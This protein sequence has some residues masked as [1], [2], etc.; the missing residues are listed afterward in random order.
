GIF[1]SLAGLWMTG[2]TLNIYSQIGIIMIIGLATKNTILIVEFAN[3]LRDE[4][5]AIHQAVWQASEERLRPILMTTVSTAIGALPLM[6]S[7]GAGAESR[8]TLG[9]VIF[10]GT[11]VAAVFTLIATPIA[12]TYIAPYT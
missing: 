2:G 12:Y 7:S 1:G 3:Q 5:M 9:V 10:F 6:L 4:G 11:L 8:F